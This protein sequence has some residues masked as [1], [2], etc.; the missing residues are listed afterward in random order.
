MRVMGRKSQFRTSSWVDCWPEGR[1]QGRS[2]KCQPHS[3]AGFLMRWSSGKYCTLPVATVSL[4]PL[5]HGSLRARA[6][7]YS[8][9]S[10]QCPAEFLAL[11][12]NAVCMNE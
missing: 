12:G 2:E 3:G 1:T 11:G 4:P 10:P 5:D 8:S 9:L 6:V 7:S